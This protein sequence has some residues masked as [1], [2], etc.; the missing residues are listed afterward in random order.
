MSFASNNKT[1]KW[2][3]IPQDFENSGQIKYA[4]C[5]VDDV[6]SAFSLF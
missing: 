2:T 3:S 6:A 1:K 4:I 5:N